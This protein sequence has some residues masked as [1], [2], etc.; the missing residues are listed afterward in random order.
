MKTVIAFLLLFNLGTLSAADVPIRFND[1]EKDNLYDSLLEEIRCLVCQNQS[2]A[3]SNA[4][5]AQDLRRQIIEMIDAGKTE[6]DIKA[7]LVERYGDFVLYR[8]PLQENTWLL[9]AGPFVFLVI[10]IV[11]AIIIIRRQANNSATQ[12][13]NND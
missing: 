8:P 3:D 1:I 12:E 7:F 9:W 4:E 6:N 5:L 11:V 2:L 13:P 10:G